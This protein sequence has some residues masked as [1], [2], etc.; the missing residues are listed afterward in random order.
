MIIATA[1]LMSISASA[2]FT[3]F[4]SVPNPPRSSYSVPSIT[5]PDP[6]E[7][8]ERHNAQVRAQAYAMEIVSSDIINADGF[9]YYNEKFSPLKIKIVRRRNG[10]VEYSC[11]GIKKN[12]T[13]RSCEKEILSLEQMYKHATSESDKTTLLELMEYGNFL[14]VIDV[15]TEVYIIK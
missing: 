1:L 10:Q 5:F 14:L 13:W 11:L 7:E 8:I 2:Q 4:Q 12:G 9:N 15:N 3:V 6:M